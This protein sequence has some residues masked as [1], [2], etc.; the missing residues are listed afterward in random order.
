MQRQGGQLWAENTVHGLRLN[1]RL[2]PDQCVLGGVAFASRHAHHRE[3][4]P[5]TNG[6]VNPNFC[7]SLLAKRFFRIRQRKNLTAGETISWGLQASDT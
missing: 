4:A 2:T 1:M 6:V 7:A 3:R 5:A